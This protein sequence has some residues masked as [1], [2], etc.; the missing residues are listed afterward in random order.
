MY[1]DLQPNTI[2][3]F[4]DNAYTENGYDNMLKFSKLAWKLFSAATIV[5]VAI[6][7]AL[8]IHVEANLPSVDM[9]RDVQ[10]QVPLKIYSADGKLIAEYGEK[11]RTPLTLEQIPQKLKDAV[12]ATEDRRFYKHPGVD[13]RGLMRAVVNLV[14]KGTKEQGGSTITMQVA[15]NFFLT[16]NK[17]YT[18]KLNEILLAL[19]IEQELSKDEILELY[20]NKIYF[21]KRAYGVAAA[22]EVYY[23]TTV[24]NL[25]LAQMAMLAGLPQAPSAINPLNSPESAIKRRKHVLDRMLT[26]ALISQAEYDEAIQQPI[27]TTYHGRPIELSAPFVAEM[28][29]QSI[30]EMYGEDVYAKGYQIITTIDS[31]LQTAA[32]NALNRAVIE[33]DQRHGYRGPIKRL[34]NNSNY[35]AELQDIPKINTLLPAVVTD[36]QEKSVTAILKNGLHI[37][38]NWEGL[39]WVKANANSAADI[40][41]TG[42]VI[43]VLPKANNEWLLTQVPQVEAAL[44]A[45]DPNN[46]AILS[47]IGGFDYEKSSFNRATQASRQPGSAFKPFIYAAALEHNFTTATIMNDAPLMQDDPNNDDWR[48][49]NYSKEF[50]GPTRLR[51]ALTHSRN[52]VSIRLLQALGIDKAIEIVS[53]FGIDPK[54]LPHGLSLALGT[55]LISPLDLTAAY[56]VFPNNGYTVKP[57]F[58]VQILDS[59]NNVVYTA[60]TTNINNLPEET[61]RA[62]TAQTA[63]LI[64]SML[65]DVIKDGSGR[66]AL[67]IGRND[68]AGKTGTTNDYVDGW[69]AGYNKDLVATTW[70][71]FDEPRS[72]REYAASI[73]LPMWTYFMEQALKGKPEHMQEQPP[74]LI[75]VRIDPTTGLLARAE[76]KDAITEWFTEQTAPKTVAKNHIQNSNNDTPTNN[77]IESDDLF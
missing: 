1:F 14:S 44:V 71:G 46:G 48:P 67:R 6:L 45:L 23:G 15:R 27:N 77:L 28:A 5:T 4:S 35:I 69:F 62:I 43:Y 73:A 22:A 68:L 8:V 17:T 29:R 31:K 75:A 7:T 24:Q 42:D 54:T 47:L 11:R 34:S 26:Y 64:T 58:I 33:Y 38:I 61:P 21:G 60:P 57:F 52:L 9:L 37:T 70:L 10:L 51:T 49:Q 63:Y 59:Q 3:P 53:K 40:L 72:L 56:S 12:I 76:Q 65:Q 13:I 74:G 19:K 55:N 41:N 66:K 30:I 16:R 20:L 39:T 36:V 50:Y 2:L 25:T 18:R 32:N